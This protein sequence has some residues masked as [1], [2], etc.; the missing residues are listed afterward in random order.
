[1]RNFNLLLHEEVSHPQ[2]WLGDITVTEPPTVGQEL[3][4]PARKHCP[5]MKVRVKHWWT[6]GQG[7][8][9]AVYLDPFRLVVLVEKI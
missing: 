1:M 5:E 9:L 8:P 7:H 6:A 2:C 4:I 3:T